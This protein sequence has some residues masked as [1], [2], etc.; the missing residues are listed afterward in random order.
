M[1]ATLYQLYEEA[2]WWGR[3]GERPELLFIKA[4][5]KEQS[6]SFAW[7]LKGK[8]RLYQDCTRM[9]AA[10]LARDYEVGLRIEWNF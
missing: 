6:L 2:G 5:R 7:A 1:G 10:T 3:E 8:L 9:L 4:T